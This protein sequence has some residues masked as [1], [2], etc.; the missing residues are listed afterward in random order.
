MK[1]IEL[2]KIPEVNSLF[3]GLLETSLKAIVVSSCD[4]RIIYSNHKTQE[5]FDWPEEVISGKNINDLIPSYSQFINEIENSQKHEWIFEAKGISNNGKKVKLDLRINKIFAEGTFYHLIRME[6]VKS[7]QIYKLDESD[8]KDISRSIPGI[9]FQFKLSKD[10]KMIFLYVSEKVTDLIG[11]TPEEVYESTDSMKMVH[12]DDYDKFEKSIFDSAKNLQQWVLEFRIYSIK[13]QAF[14]W[15]SGSSTP[16]K[17]EDGSIIWNG[18][19]LDITHKKLTEESLYNTEQRLQSHYN[20]TPLGVIE[21]LKDLTI[22][23]WN[24]AAEQTYGY[25]IHEAEDKNLLNL[26]FNEADHYA[27]NMLFRS[28]ILK[29]ESEKNIFKNVTKT[30]DVIFCEW[31]CTPFYNQSGEI[32]GLTFLVNDITKRYKDEE[33]IKLQAAYFQ[34]LFDACPFGIVM[35]DAE[36]RVLMCNQGF[37]KIFQYSPN[38]IT[39]KYINNLIVP[40]KAWEEAYSISQECIG[41]KAAQYETKRKRKDGSL[42]DVMVVGCP[43]IV[44]EKLIGIYGIYADITSRKDYER[45]L[46]VQNEELRK[47]NEELDRFVYSASHDLRA[48][49]TSILGLINISEIATQEPELLHYF[50]LMKKSVDRLD[51]FIKDIID[52]SRNSRLGLNYEKIDFEKLVNESFENFRFISGTEKIKFHI[53]LNEEAP[54]YNDRQRI[55]ILINNL[56]S[57][58]IKYHR[59]NQDNPF[60]KVVIKCDARTC[61]LLIEDNGEGISKEYQQ[62]VFDMFYRASEKSVGS[63]LGL[64]IVKEILNKIDGKLKLISKSR[65]G[66]RFYISIPNKYH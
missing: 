3:N 61:S 5:I 41:Q 66:T 11:I 52:Y 29:K 26:L 64:Y 27:F 35:L 33:T 42:I 7:R 45:Q 4:G 31:Y 65:V 38:E 54:F 50:S 32:T 55:N 19:I 13:D 44:N 48:P 40:D 22:I 30:G 43:I 21:V 59:L 62:K 17:K 10:L 46:Q 34:Q 56:I 28:I 49:L 23:G 18:T 9:V 47:T 12:P 57:N 37:Q 58:A 14:K 25:T 1:G 60:I 51:G 15:F 2:L 20:E 24:P 53:D 63:G 8:L 39:G 6:K 36:D 16:S